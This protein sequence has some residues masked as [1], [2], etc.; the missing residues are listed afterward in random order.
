MF[1]IALLITSGAYLLWILTI[2]MNKHV[3]DVRKNK[4]RLWHITDIL[5]IL[6]DLY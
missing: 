1:L 4:D 2:V 6:S 5:I 3:W